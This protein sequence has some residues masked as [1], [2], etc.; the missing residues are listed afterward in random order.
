MHLYN[1][2]K[3]VIIDRVAHCLHSLHKDIYTSAH[4]TVHK[5]LYGL[6]CRKFHSRHV[7]ISGVFSYLS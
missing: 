6:P 1:Y 2:A 3:I 5:L 7:F 4:I